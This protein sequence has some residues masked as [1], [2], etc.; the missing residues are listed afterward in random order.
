MAYEE[1]P[2]LFIETTDELYRSNIFRGMRRD[3]NLAIG[4]EEFKGQIVLEVMGDN[5]EVR[6]GF[7]TGYDEYD[8]IILGRFDKNQV[9]FILSDVNQLQNTPV[10][11]IEDSV[12]SY[13]TMS[14]F[15]HLYAHRCQYTPQQILEYDF[16]GMSATYETMKFFMAML[17][18]PSG[19]CVKPTKRN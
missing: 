3:S 4:G 8:E 19:R 12:V 17:R 13:E 18:Q 15:L 6:N 9:Y 10:H 14:L 11:D 16:S 7:W 5:V 1:P 2:Q